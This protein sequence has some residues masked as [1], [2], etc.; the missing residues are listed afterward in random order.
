[1]CSCGSQNVI[2]DPNGNL[3][4]TLLKIPTVPLISGPLYEMICDGTLTKKLIQTMLRDLLYWSIFTDR[5]DMAK[6]LLLHLQTRI[7]AAL[8][9]AA[10]LRNRANAATISDQGDFYRQQATDF[11]MYATDCINAC[12]STS[13]RKACELLIRQQ[14]LFGKITCMQ[15][16]IP[17]ID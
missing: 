6:I 16:S 7:C 2:E 4:E 14:P 5:I 1:M 12:Y 3:K 11:E 9:C 10:I 17:H 8:S 15:V 13:E